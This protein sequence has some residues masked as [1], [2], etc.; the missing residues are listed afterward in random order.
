ME[1]YIQNV[2]AV[3]FKQN[4]T[5]SFV[6]FKQHYYVYSNRKMRFASEYLVLS[7]PSYFFFFEPCANQGVWDGFDS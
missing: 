5:Y 1:L 6:S 3:S 7:Y 4:N 2:L